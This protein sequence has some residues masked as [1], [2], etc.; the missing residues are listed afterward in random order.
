LI[1]VDRDVILARRDTV[2][3]PVPVDF[4]DDPALCKASQ[5]GCNYATVL[6][7]AVELPEGV[8]EVSFERGFVAVDATVEG[9]DFRYVATHLEVREPEPGNVVSRV[10]QTAQAAQLIGLLG[11]TTPPGLTQIVVGDLNSSP[12]DEPVPGPLPLP[13]PLDQGLPPPY[14][15]FV[16]AGYT[17]AWTLRPGA[18]PGFTCCQAPDLLNPRSTLD[19]R[20]DL[21]FASDAP[22]TV[23]QARVVGARVADKTPPPSPR[24]W[25]SDHGGVVA[26]LEFD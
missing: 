12:E 26:T 6:P 7:V 9:K 13:P 5:Q 18:L 19:E 4:P 11:A 20:I 10:F 25:P 14:L 8:L 16:G 23:R 15:Q 21:I 2:L 3:D 24:L 17:D 22:T 1:A